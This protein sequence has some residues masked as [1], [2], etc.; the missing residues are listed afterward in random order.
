MHAF[1]ATLRLR[2]AGVL[3]VA[4][5][6]RVR[7]VMACSPC[8][9][10][11]QTGPVLLCTAARDYQGRSSHKGCFS[12]PGRLGSHTACLDA[13]HHRVRLFAKTPSMEVPH[14]ASGVA[15][16][17]LGSGKILSQGKHYTHNKGQHERHVPSPWG[18]GKYTMIC[19]DSKHSLVFVCPKGASINVPH[20]PAGAGK[21]LASL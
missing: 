6:R 19:V 11:P 1:V 16:Q 7:I 21:V 12:R 18:L 3:G 15:K 8:D 17:V 5:V 10:K 13:T 14:V 9:V 4:S 2:Y 20:L